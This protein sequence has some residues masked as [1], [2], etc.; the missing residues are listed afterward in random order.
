MSY[1]YFP[2]LDYHFRHYWENS[3]E[4][5][6]NHINLAEIEIYNPKV[7]NIFQLLFDNNYNLTYY[8]HLFSLISYSSLPKP[9]YERLNYIRPNVSIYESRES[10]INALNLTDMDILMLD[11]LLLYRNGDEM[12]L[13]YIE[14]IDLD[15]NLSCL[16][17]AYLEVMLDYNFQHINNEE[18]KSGNNNLETL[19]EIY[20]IN[21][22]HKVIKNW[23]FFI[24][25]GVINLRPWRQKIKI[26][27]S[28]EESGTASL[29]YFPNMESDLYI[30]H[31]GAKLDNEL[32]QISCDGTNSIDST[33]CISWSRAEI[34]IKEEDILL[35]DY[36]VEVVNN[37]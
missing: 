26:T 25:S 2:E 35:I 6:T 5:T 20:V 10:G 27:P 16:I 33:C 23:Q 9:L 11:L 29:D 19:F 31:N 8:N 3:G 17:Y 1:I 24:D 21:E 36:Y 30:I 37:V 34:N 7:A 32:F 14:Y 18:I 15:T 13:E 22:C 28:L 4:I 12:S